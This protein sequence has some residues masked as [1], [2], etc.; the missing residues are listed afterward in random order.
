MYIHL[1][2]MSKQGLDYW[3]LV[4]TIENHQKR[5]GV[6][7]L[8]EITNERRGRKGTRN[9]E[10]VGGETRRRGEGR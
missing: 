1:Y 3:L 7:E 8:A 2:N 9:E 10:R 5:N 4:Q 6:T